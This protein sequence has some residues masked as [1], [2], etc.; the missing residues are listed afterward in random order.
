VKELNLGLRF[1]LELCLLAALAYAGLQVHVL[2]AI[3]APLAAAVVWGLLV[4]PKAPVS[5]PTA[6]WVAVQVI[7][8]GAAVVGLVLA[9]NPLL[10]ITFAIAVVINLALVLFWGRVDTVT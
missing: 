10:A 6:V 3:A 9:G 8:F 2:L 4:S 5:L 7:L 1:L